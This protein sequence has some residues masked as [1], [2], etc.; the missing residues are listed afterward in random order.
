MNIYSDLLLIFT[1]MFIGWIFIPIIY[2]FS[3]QVYWLIIYSDYLYSLV[4]FI[5]WIFILIFYWF[6]Q[7]YLLV[8]SLPRLFINFCRHVYWLNLHPDCLLIFADMFIGWIFIPIIYLFLQTCL[9]VV[10]SSRLLIYFYRHNYWLYVHPDYL[11]IFADMYIGWIF[12]LIIYFWCIL[13]DV[14]WQ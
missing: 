13:F 2:L 12:I 10:S 3:S 4:M 6:L 7:T 9:L 8:E 11:F 5:G 14:R 1:D